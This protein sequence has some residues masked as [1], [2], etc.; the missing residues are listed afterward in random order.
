MGLSDAPDLPGLRI[1]EELGP[2]SAGRPPR[3]FGSLAAIVAEV[4]DDL[5]HEADALGATHAVSVRVEVTTTL[6]SVG[7][8]ARGLAVRARA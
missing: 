3:L 5:R 2:V 1:V 7:A 4:E 8:S 6:L